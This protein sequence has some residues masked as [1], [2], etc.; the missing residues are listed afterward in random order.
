MCIIVYN[1][2]QG[3]EDYMNL[4]YKILN[5]HLK[6]GELVPGT[7]I[8]IGID[9]TLTQDSTGTMAYLQLEAMNVGHVAV[10]KAVAYI[11][12]NM[13]QTGFENM[14]DH[15]FIKS[16]ARKH[17]ITFSKPGNGVCHQL[18]LE[19]FSHPGKTLIGS[20]SHTPTC[21][22]M[23]MIAIGAGGLDVAVAMATGKYYV[24]C[25]SVLQVK[26]TGRK[27][28]WVSAKDVI[29]KIL[30]ELSVKGG[31]N[32][33]VEYTG[34][35]LSDLSLTDRATICNMGAEL[36][37]TTSVFPTDEYTLAYL[38]QQGR[39]DEYVEMKADDDATYDET[40]E[41]DMSTLVPMVAQPH[42]PDNVVDV[43]ELEG[44]KINQVVIGSCTNSS[45]PDM[46]RAAK[47]LKGRKVAE[48]VSLVIAPGSSS[49]L[50]M[51]AQNG[52]LADM[53]HAGARILECGCGPCIGM[54]QAPL[55]KGVSLR[56]I[57]RNFKGR[58]GTNDASVYLVSPEVAALSAVKGYLSQEFEDDM[59]LEEVPDTPF[60]KNP[61]FFIS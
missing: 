43:K 21:G 16:V 14:D 40:I 5:A 28:P 12:H 24:Q 60:V 54:G 30:Q 48:D 34:E 45:L 37:A 36:G 55:S 23:G 59:V 3:G 4:A 27:A 6:K 2:K 56:T 39:E 52:A 18:Q 9:Q 1:K 7:S 51:L 17:G 11:D 10:E 32:K 8:C 26:L 47:I 22:A 15:E 50:S 42:S 41:I 31:V 49:I 44:M 25:P 29:L 20:D 19:N 46:M 35:G 57:N 13:L 38:K 53:I 61:N 33:I 58:S